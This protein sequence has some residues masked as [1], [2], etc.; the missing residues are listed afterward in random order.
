[1]I[2][3]KTM[4]NA[5]GET[6]KQEIRIELHGKGGETGIKCVKRMVE[7]VEKLKAFDTPE[8]I[9]R[10][11][12]AVCGYTQCCADAGFIDE[13]GADEFMQLISVLAG[14]EMERAEKDGKG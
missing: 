9:D 3:A 14:I 2:R 12:Y 6:K 13:A 1:M 8:E 11:F 10:H 4:F 7:L 5:N